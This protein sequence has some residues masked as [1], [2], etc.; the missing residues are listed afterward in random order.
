MAWEDTLRELPGTIRRRIGGYIGDRKADG[1]APMG[2]GCRD[3]KDVFRV[4]GRYER[5]GKV[6]PEHEDLIRDYRMYV[7]GEGR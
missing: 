7:K 4:L 5:T 3:W 2:E 1:G 6:P